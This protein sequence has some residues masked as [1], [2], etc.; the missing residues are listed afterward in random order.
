MMSKSSEESLRTLSKYCFSLA[1]VVEDVVAAMDH[2]NPKGALQRWRGARQGLPGHG[3]RQGMPAE[4]EEGMSCSVVCS[5]QR[6]CAAGD[7]GPPEARI[8]HLPLPPPAAAVK[9]ETARFVKD[10]LESTPKA[11]LSRM[12]D[13][14][15]PALAKLAG[16][17][18]SDV[19]EAAQA[20]LVAFAV[21]AGSM[22]ALDKVGT[23][24][25][26]V[27]GAAGLMCSDTRSRALSGSRA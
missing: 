11:L 5:T 2:K 25:V 8:H 22:S 10:A 13:T 17:G 26:L 21:R 16:A 3:C 6:R 12:R 23:A 24:W 9:R 1:D 18:E 19:R 15:L 7:G 20:A 4:L 27:A 14:L